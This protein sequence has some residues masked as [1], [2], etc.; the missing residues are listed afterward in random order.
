LTYSKPFDKITIRNSG[1]EYFAD[2]NNGGISALEYGKLMHKIFENIKRKNDVETAVINLVIEGFIYQKEI[3]DWIKQVNEYLD[4]KEAS[5]WFSDHWMIMNESTILTP[6]G[7]MYRPD[8]VISDAEQTIIIDYKFSSEIRNEHIRQM[9]SYVN[10]LKL[11]SY[12]NI[13]AYLWYVDS[14]LVKQVI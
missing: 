4:F 8:R 7:K 12:K 11:M 3:T 5:G 6:G 2:T 14:Y 1:H 9:E 10:N 13:S